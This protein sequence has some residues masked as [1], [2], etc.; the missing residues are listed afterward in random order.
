MD[1]N[2]I[3]YQQVALLVRVL[4]WLETLDCFALKGGTA[5]NLRM[6]AALAEQRNQFVASIA[7]EV[8]FIHAAVASQTEQLAQNNLQGGKN[9]FTLNCPENKNMLDVGVRGINV[10]LLHEIF[11]S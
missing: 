11:G 2:S 7:D 10:P 5:I 8:L 9:T 6:T 1:P 4:P 3:Y